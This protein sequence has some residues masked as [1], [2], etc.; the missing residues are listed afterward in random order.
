MVAEDPSEGANYGESVSISDDKILVG[1]PNDVAVSPTLHG[2]CLD[3][4]PR[5]SN[6]Y[7]S[8]VPA[9]QSQNRYGSAYFYY[10]KD[11]TWTILEKLE[12]GSQISTPGATFGQSVAV[13]SN[14]MVTGAPNADI[15][16][17]NSGSIFINNIISDCVS[18]V[19]AA[20]DSITEPPSY[21]P[22]YYPF[23]FPT[24]SP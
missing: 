24:L 12:P 16:V 7:F 5:H 17:D 13:S 23:Y 22:T 1:A 2:S 15:T 11:E 21:Y 20:E 6:P 9:V 10:L 4:L 19:S 14:A 18:L 3:Q 8:C